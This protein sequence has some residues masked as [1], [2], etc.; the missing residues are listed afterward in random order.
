MNTIKI[1]E[2]YEYLRGH[3]CVEVVYY[4]TVEIIKGDTRRINEN[5]ELWK[6]IIE[7]MNINGFNKYEIVKY[8]SGS[9]Y[10]RWME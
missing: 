1:Q 9:G 2:P 3:K 4:N 8:K 10:Y 7:V 6:R 5:N